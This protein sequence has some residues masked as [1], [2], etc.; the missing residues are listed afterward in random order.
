MNIS[1]SQTKILFLEACNFVNA[2]LGGQL[3]AAR[4]LMRALGTRLA[5]AGW[6]DDPKATIGCW[7]KRDIDG[8]EYDFFATDYVPIPQHKR[9]L[10]PTR[11]TS[12]FQ[13]MRYGQ[14]ILSI[15]IPNVLIREPTIMIALPFAPNHNVCFWS[16][17]IEP[18]LSVSRYQWAKRFAPWFDRVLNRRLHRFAKTILAAAD[19]DAINEWRYRVKGLLD[20]CTIRSFPTRVNT[21]LFFPGDRLNARLALSSPLDETVCVTTGRLHRAKGWPLI[22][23]AFDAFLTRNSNARLIFVGDGSDRPALERAIRQK[24]VENRV[25]LAGQQPPEKLAVYLKAADLFVM[26]SEKEGWSTSLLE[27]LASGL[28]IVTT[29]FSSADSIVRNGLN[30]FVVNRDSIVFASAMA[31]ALELKGVKEYSKNEIEKYSLANLAND[32]NDAWLSRSVNYP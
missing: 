27:A 15:G 22:L 7:H 11:A 21:N 26:G 8:V 16:P 25:F 17:G 23:D 3:T 2:P 4:M 13:F 24:G 10:V 18:A 31:D 28:P 20:S 12:L 19:P 32:L 9:P 5:L 1:S 6:T 29:R 30:G 14:A